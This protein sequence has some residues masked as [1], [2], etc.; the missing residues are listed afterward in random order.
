[1][2]EMKIKIVQGLLKCDQKYQ[3]ISEIE[4]SDPFDHIPALEQQNITK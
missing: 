2:P 1:M 3:N 4:S